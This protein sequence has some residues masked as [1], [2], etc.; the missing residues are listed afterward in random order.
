VSE[1]FFDV[2]QI[3]KDD[4]GKEK[5]VMRILPGGWEDTKIMVMSIEEVEPV[6]ANIF[7]S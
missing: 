6:A 7:D 5:L 2:M 3:R 1:I 4:A